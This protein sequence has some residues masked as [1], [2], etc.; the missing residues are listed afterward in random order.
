[1]KKLYLF[2]PQQSFVFDGKKSYWLPYSV[3]CLWSYARQNQTVSGNYSLEG[4]YFKRSKIDRVIDTMHDPDIA[5]FSCYVW[6]W[7]YNLLLA[8][9]IKKSWPACLIVF[10]GP[11]VT[12]RPYENSFFQKHPYVDVIINGEGEIAFENLLVDL[13]QGKKPR[14]VIEFTRLTDLDYPSP[15]LSGVFDKLI[16]DHPDYSWQM[17]LETNRGC[18]YACTFCDWGSLIY[19]KV[20]KFPEKRVLDELTWAS[21]HKVE[22]L[23]IADAN[24]GI[25]Y[26]R[27]KKFAEHL[28][29]LQIT[30][31]YPSMV[32]AQWAKN[33]KEKTLDIAKIFFN[34]ANRGFTISVQ[35]MNDA[36]LEAIKRKNMDISNIE[37]MLKECEKLDIPAYTELILGL[38]YETKQSWKENFERLLEAGQ[39]NAVDVWLCE[40]LENSELN[41]QEQMSQHEIEFV[42]IP[43]WIYGVSDEEDLEIVEYENIIKSTK[44]MSF[45]DLIDC[46]MFSHV[47][48]TYHYGGWSQLLARF[49]HK[50]QQI[51]YV[52]FYSSLHEYIKTSNGL[53]NK[54]YEMIKKWVLA[55]MTGNL[56]TINQDLYKGQE[57]HSVIWRAMKNIVLTPDEIFSEIF[58]YVSPKFCNN[59]KSLYRDL[60]QAQ[61]HFMYDHN[62]T[63]PKLVDFD[64][65][66]YGYTF[67]NKDLKRSCKVN[68]E[69]KYKWKNAQ[70]LK[71]SAYIARRKPIF[72]TVANT[73]Y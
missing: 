25:F 11:Q 56:H 5:V 48:L 9:Q 67:E 4:M 15:Y 69:Y 6:N 45:D 66:I 54:E 14:R 63:Y 27:D 50:H 12:K 43:R 8:E 29:H 38:P 70:H 17:V 44:Y 72:R 36:V 26:E 65:D 40:L 58:S 49:L 18:P 7:Q 53:L 28:N 39:H 62:Q 71:E 52:D 19:S 2:Q 20:L 37:S 32:I 57:L 68:F 51:S 22:Y 60:L 35:S 55:A 21:Q 30:T 59:D 13:V 42:K 31:D 46:Y 64:H 73:I 3:G 23:F 24:F 1:M 33:S 10:G 34:Q 16:S 61:I 41:S 47:I